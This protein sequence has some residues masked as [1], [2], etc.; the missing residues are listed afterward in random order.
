MQSSKPAMKL[1]HHKPHSEESDPES[2]HSDA[3]DDPPPKK[4]TH[5]SRSKSTSSSKPKPNRRKRDVNKADIEKEEYQ[6]GESDVDL[7]DGQAPLVTTANG[8]SYVHEPVYRRTEDEFK[9]FIE[10][11]TNMLTEVDSQIPPLPPKDVIHRI[12]RDIR[13]LPVTSFREPAI[14]KSC[15]FKAQDETSN[16][17]VLPDPI[18]PPKRKRGKCG[19]NKADIE[20]KEENEERSDCPTIKRVLS[21]LDFH[22][23]P[24]YVLPSSIRNNLLH[25]NPTAKT[26]YTILSSGKA[27]TTHF[28]PRRSHPHEECQRVFGHEDELKV[29]MTLE[30]LKLNVENP[31]GSGNF[32]PVPP[33]PGTV[34]F[35]IGDS[36]TRWSNDTLKSTLHRVRASSERWDGNDQGT[37]L[38][39][40]SCLRAEIFW[41]IACQAVR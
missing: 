15:P 5:S 14:L 27:F 9:E 39:P 13:L 25:S 17:R 32:V 11:F 36:L 16:V 31:D 34:I 23:G 21:P 37:L 10:E 38:D 1:K 7:K 6:E 8:S 20:K 26:P 3:L 22:D 18:Q 19:V 28:G 24:F 30:G 12:Y 40:I 2:L 4:R 41:L 29:A 33:I 35:N